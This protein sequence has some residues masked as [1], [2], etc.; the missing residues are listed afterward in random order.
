MSLVN[1]EWVTNIHIKRAIEAPDFQTDLLPEI[2]THVDNEIIFRCRT[3]QVAVDEITKDATGY[4]TSAILIKFGAEYL[5]YKI[6]LDLGEADDENQENDVYDG[7][8]KQYKELYESTA[9][10]MSRDLI[11]DEEPEEPIAKADLIYN[12]PLF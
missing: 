9:N 7:V 8:R 1:V 11:V 6:A 3:S 12:V 2:L 4:V 10:M 5:T